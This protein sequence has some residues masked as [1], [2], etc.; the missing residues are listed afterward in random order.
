MISNDSLGH[1][2][3]D[4]PVMNLSISSVGSFLNTTST[5]TNGLLSKLVLVLVLGGVGFRDLKYSID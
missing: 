5:E 4:I 3:F 2:I 1:F